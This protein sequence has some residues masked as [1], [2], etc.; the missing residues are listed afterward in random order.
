[1]VMGRAHQP[2]ERRPMDMTCHHLETIQQEN[3]TWETSQAVERRSGEIL[4]GHDLAEDCARQA[5]LEAARM[6]M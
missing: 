6:C 2:P 3:T 5:N 4:E 1:M